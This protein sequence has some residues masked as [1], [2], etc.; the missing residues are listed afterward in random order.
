VTEGATRRV[1]RPSMGLERRRQIVSAFID[2]VA[3]RGLERVTLADVAEAAGVQRA[4]LR[5]FIGNREDLV[6]AAVDELARRYEVSA[7]EMYVSEEPTIDQ[8]I[9]LLF[10]DELV[11]DQP[12]ETA[13]FDA[14][15][16]EA[17]LRP[18][19]RGAVIKGYDML[20]GQLASALRREYPGA[21]I[22]RIRDVAYVVLCLVEQNTL[23]QGLGYPRVRQ[24]AAAN[25]ARRQVARLAAEFGA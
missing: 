6:L 2:L 20:L 12:V 3:E 5:H 7:A 22:A 25:A 10:S 8:L 9:S 18:A 11:Y 15:L 4:Q 19:G 23:L 13:A 21:P 1:G 16:A 24:L 14:L 17:V